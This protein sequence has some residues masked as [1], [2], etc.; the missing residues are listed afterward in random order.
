MAEI[1]P[2]P[3]PDLFAGSQLI[4]LGTYP[5]GGPATLTLRGEVNGE[6]GVYLPGHLHQGWR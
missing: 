5:D 4:A 2:A 3:L 1:Y 6:P